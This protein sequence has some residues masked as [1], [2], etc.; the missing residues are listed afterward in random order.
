M[1][2]NQNIVLIGVGHWSTGGDISH[3]LWEWVVEN[4]KITKGVVSGREKISF[5]EEI[6]PLFPD[7]WQKKL[8]VPDCIPGD[9]WNLRLSQNEFTNPGEAEKILEKYFPYLFKEFEIVFIGLPHEDKKFERLFYF[10]RVIGTNGPYYE[11]HGMRKQLYFERDFNKYKKSESGNII[12]L[13]IPIPI[14]DD[15][16]ETIWG[17]KLPSGE[18]VVVIAKHSATHEEILELSKTKNIIKE[19]E[20]EKLE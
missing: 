10:T 11:G 12:K 4:R 6:Q 19:N 3:H 17:M 2:T 16:E 9:A 14:E 7:N 13:K 8:D 15:Y 5:L 20:Y 18:T 1:E